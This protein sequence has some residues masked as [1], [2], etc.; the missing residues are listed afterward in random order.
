M[1]ATVM[2]Y[3]QR[4]AGCLFAYI[5]HVGTGDVHAMCYVK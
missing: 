3:V 4:I 2:L 5:K 1:T